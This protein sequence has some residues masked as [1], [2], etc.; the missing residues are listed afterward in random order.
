MPHVDGTVVAYVG[1]ALHS[2][3]KSKRCAKVVVS[4]PGRFAPVCHLCAPFATPAPA[5][6]CR[7]VKPD[8]RG[9]PQAVACGPARPEV[10]WHRDCFS[11]G[12]CEPNR[13]IHRS[14]L[15]SSAKQTAVLGPDTL[16]TS[17]ASN[18]SPE[19]AASFVSQFFAIAAW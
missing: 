8:K 14:F 17:F 2:R 9:F 5:W 16:R 11:W 10:M 4:T 3:A 12:S 1:I 6:H 15:S 13:S 19:C 18:T 7:I